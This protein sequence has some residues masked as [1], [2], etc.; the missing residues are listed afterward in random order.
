[1]FGRWL[2]GLEKS[3]LNGVIHGETGWSTFWEREAK[4]R[5][6]FVSRV[7]EGNGI[8][9]KVGKACVE[10]IGVAAKWWRG[11]VSLGRKMGIDALSKGVWKKMSWAGMQEM[12]V[13]QR[14]M[15]KM[16]KKE[17][18]VRIKEVLREEKKFPRIFN[19]RSRAKLDTPQPLL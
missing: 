15:E 13:T 19:I 17:L 1:M 8:V 5:A 11:V 9:A 4:D 12:G 10:E 2:W 16:R 6:S 7:M 3:V 18:E 14:Q